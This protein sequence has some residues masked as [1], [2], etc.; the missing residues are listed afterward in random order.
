M[1]VPQAVNDQN[2]CKR[3]R[4]SLPIMHVNVQDSSIDDRK[5]ISPIIS[6]DKDMSLDRHSYLKN[7]PRYLAISERPWDRDLTTCTIKARAANN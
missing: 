1:Q 5:A 2:L 6:G 4:T 7:L 3:L